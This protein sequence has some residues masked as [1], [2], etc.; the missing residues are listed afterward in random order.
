MY[1]DEELEKF[2]DCINQ[3]YLQVGGYEEILHMCYWDFISIIET[4]NNNKKR[5]SGKR[6]THDKIPQSSQDMI[7][8]SKKSRK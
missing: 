4:L 6:V 2:R 8:R 1:Y 7:D 5:S 3:L